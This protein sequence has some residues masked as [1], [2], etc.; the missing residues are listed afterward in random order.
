[1]N[2]FSKGWIGRLLCRL[3]EHDVWQSYGHYRGY[4]KVE[5]E[6]CCRRCAWT[7]TERL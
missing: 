7:R 4:W 3:G 1:M 6:Y 5:A 2:W